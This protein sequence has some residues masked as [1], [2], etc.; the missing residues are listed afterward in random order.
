MSE[1]SVASTSALDL[2]T[3]AV[4]RADDAERRAWTSEQEMQRLSQ[5]QRESDLKAELLRIE[6]S[7]LQRRIRTAKAMLVAIEAAAEPDDAAEARLAR[8]V[9]EGYQ[10][11]GGEAVLPPLTQAADSSK[12]ANRG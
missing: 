11:I 3:L 2:V 8:K 7:D 10:I 4:R 6:R 1:P 12:E 9:L 5:W